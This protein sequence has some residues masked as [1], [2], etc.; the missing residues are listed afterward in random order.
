MINIEDVTMQDWEALRGDELLRGALL[1]GARFYGDREV[2]GAVLLDQASFIGM[3]FSKEPVDPNA[4]RQYR[5]RTFVSDQLKD[6]ITAW[7]YV[8][9]RALRTLAAFWAMRTVG[10]PVTIQMNPWKLAHATTYDARGAEMFARTAH[11][12]MSAE[13][14]AAGVELNVITTTL[15]GTEEHSDI[16]LV[17][18]SSAATKT[19]TAYGPVLIDAQH[20]PALI[21][22]IAALLRGMGGLS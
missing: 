13:A 17:A 16:G 6:E 2:L 20:G 3:T 7:Q 15:E 4:G 12:K 11:Q 14:S 22:R 5:M 21:A 9:S 8:H 19:F 10:V 18:V 1:R